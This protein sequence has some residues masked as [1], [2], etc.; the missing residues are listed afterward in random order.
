MK[1]DTIVLIHGFWVTPR[2]WEHWKTR[3]E[4]QGYQFLTPAY[5]GLEVEVEALNTDP[6]PIEKLTVPAI[7][8]HLERS[9]RTCPARRSSLDTPPAARSPRSCS[10]TATAPPASPSTLRLPRASG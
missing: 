9:S 1:P 8:G 6:I 2:S 3:Y 5:P 4:Q 7:V 10:T